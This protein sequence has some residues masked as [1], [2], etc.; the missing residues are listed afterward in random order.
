MLADALDRTLLLMRTDLV[1]GVPSERLLSALTSTSV[2]LVAGDDVLA[3][4]SGQSAF[5]TAAMLMARSGHSVWLEAEDVGLLGPQ[6]PLRLPTLTS[7]LRELGAD[8]LPGWS[9]QKGPP[10]ASVDLVV[11]FGGASFSGAPAHVLRLDADDWSA[12]CGGGGAGWSGGEWPVGGLAAAALAAGEAFK[13][14]MRDL[15]TAAACPP[16]FDELYA[17]AAD[18]TVALAPAGTRKARRLGLFDIVSGGAIGNGVLHALLR[19]PDVTGAARVMDDDTSALSN[20]NRNALLRRS[21]LD[22]AKVED[23]ASYSGGLEIVP[24]VHRYGSDDGS[25]PRLADTVL[26]GVDHIPSRWAAQRSDPEWLGIGATE[27]FFVQVSAHPRGEACAQCLHPEGSP[28]EGEIPT[29]AF[30][31]YWA[32]LLLS[33]SLLRRCAADEAGPAERQAFFPALRPEAWSAAW[34]SVAARE[35]CP[36][37]SVMVA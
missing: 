16:M 36:T 17:P 25:E 18:C 37:C 26:V 29:V 24:I 21:R 34:S 13:A 4:H 10:P 32:G 20:L 23:L 15:R 14:A 5:V 19:M 22:L 12:A 1:P 35:G 7:A 9:F 2:V 6:P 33:V 27:R 11:A 31:S 30:V 3:T 28:P 8:L